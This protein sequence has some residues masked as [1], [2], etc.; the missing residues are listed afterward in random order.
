VPFEVALDEIDPGDEAVGDMGVCMEGV[1]GV[2]IGVEVGKRLPWFVGWWVA[3]T[4][5][6]ALVFVVG[7]CHKTSVEDGGAPW[8]RIVRVRV[9][10]FVLE[11]VRGLWKYLAEDVFSK[12]EIV[13]YRVAVLVI[14]AVITVVL[15][16]VLLGIIACMSCLAALPAART[17]T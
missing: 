3:L 8:G 6:S 11:C 13:V 5:P 16:G 12:T 10:L 2:E 9:G 1:A 7:V 4:L 17:H 14:D 15:T